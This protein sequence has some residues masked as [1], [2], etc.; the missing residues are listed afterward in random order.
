MGRA[1][2]VD[3]GW[4][5]PPL[6]GAHCCTWVPLAE[7]TVWVPLIATVSITMSF[8]PLATVTLRGV[9]VTAVI[10]GKGPDGGGLVGAGEG[11]SAN[12]C[13]DGR[14]PAAADVLGYYNIVVAGRRVDQ[15]PHLYPAHV[16]GVVV[17]LRQT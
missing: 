13:P 5:A 7:V 15:I 8:A 9:A 4:P 11:C 10:R 6:V 17:E 16:G 12:Y 14:V 1:V 2:S 3:I